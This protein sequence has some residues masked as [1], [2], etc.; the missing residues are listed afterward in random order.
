MERER[1]E[2]T[3]RYKTNNPT[4]IKEDMVL[5]RISLINYNFNIAINLEISRI[6][7]T[8]A[9]YLNQIQS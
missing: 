3:Q 8:H 7:I 6:S 2:W 5:G 9:N 4:Q 1:C